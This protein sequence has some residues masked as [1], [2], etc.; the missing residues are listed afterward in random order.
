MSISE[1]CSVKIR[2][3]EIFL[4]EYN[5]AMCQIIDYLRKK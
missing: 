5:D 3:A 1:A 4:I 2:L